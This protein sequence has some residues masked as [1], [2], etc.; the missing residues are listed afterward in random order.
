MSVVKRIHH[1]IS[2]DRRIGDDDAFSKEDGSKDSLENNLKSEAGM[3]R[4]TK[5]FVEDLTGLSFLPL[6][7]RRSI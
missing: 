4:I 2:R 1:R 7:A 3:K 5:D 6:A